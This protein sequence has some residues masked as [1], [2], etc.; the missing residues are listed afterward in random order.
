MLTFFVVISIFVFSHLVMKYFL[1]PLRGL[2]S[3]NHFLIG[4]DFAIGHTRF[5]DAALRDFLNLRDTP[6][7][8][9]YLILDVE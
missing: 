5:A 7:G 4:Y 6:E 9:P 8:Y 3:Q 2:S 1:F